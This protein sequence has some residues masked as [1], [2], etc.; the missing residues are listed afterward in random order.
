MAL[1]EI[2][3]PIY[4]PTDTVYDAID[5]VVGQTFTDW[6]LTVVDDCSPV[7]IG[8]ALLSKYSSNGQI[9]YLRLDENLK[10]A[11]ARNFVIAN[12]TSDFLALQDQDDVWLP[13]KLEK[14]V[15]FFHSLPGSVGAIHG[16][17]EMINVDG[18]I[19]PNKAKSENEARSRVD[20]TLEPSQLQK[21]IF[22]ASN[23][24]LI[25]SMMR[26]SAFQEIG[27]FDANLTG[28]EDWEFWV[29]LSGKYGIRH[30][31]Q[32]LIY[33]RIH[34][35]NVSKV[36]GMTRNIDTLKVLKK[37]SLAGYNIPTELFEEKEYRVYATII[38]FLRQNLGV[39]EAIPY[40][41]DFVKKYP[42]HILRHM[43]LTWYLAFGSRRIL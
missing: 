21:S 26:R 40:L 1:V 35:N 8:D 4:N 38:R 41:T 15:T 10:A 6:H 13:E 14:Q 20:W 12:C 18:E 23:I 36:S 31:P 42:S 28:D 37:I 7:N 17:I 32:T 5:S 19:T 2:I 24:R 16:D 27:G 34:D 29:R 11:G 9:S 22:L 25:T 33:R 3:L 43:K 30:I 39:R